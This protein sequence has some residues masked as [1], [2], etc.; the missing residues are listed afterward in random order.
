MSDSFG[1][2]RW[3]ESR[4][5]QTQPDQ[6]LVQNIQAGKI[7]AVQHFPQQFQGRIADPLPI[8]IFDEKLSLIQ[9]RI[10]RNSSSRLENAS[11]LVE[12]TAIVSGLA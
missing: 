6:F 12:A 1:N 9:S 2:F 11:P 7:P 5:L 3:T 8:L 10:R 4:I